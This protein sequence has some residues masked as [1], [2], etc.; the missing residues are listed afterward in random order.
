MATIGRLEKQ[1]GHKYLLEALKRVFVINW[2]LK[3]YGDGKLRRCLGLQAKIKK[4]NKN[5]EFCGVAHNLPE[6]LRGVDI[7]V[8]PSLW[9]G[10]SLVVM[11]AMAAGRLVI[12]TP[13]AGD[14]LIEN[15][16]TGL[17]AK[18]GSAGDLANALMAVDMERDL[19]RVMA[20]S[21]REFA[22][23]HFGLEKNVEK[24]EKVYGEN[25]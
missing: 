21:G 9:E 15:F 4:I 13:P 17:I 6:C 20:A 23:K 5:V 2:S 11:E 16:K 22:K 8:Q 1:K 18:T 3:I 14:E 25:F 12:T 10:L 7:V 19:A 24:L